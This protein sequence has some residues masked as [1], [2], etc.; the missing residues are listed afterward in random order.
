MQYSIM[1]I[2]NLIVAIIVIV[3]AVNW[4]AVAGL[5]MDLVKMI[6]PGHAD[7]ERYI[8]IA[9][10]LAGIYYAYLVYTWKTQQ[11]ETAAPSA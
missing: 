5:N 1:H 7:I 9:V 10:G 3:G 6:T 2:L 8:K 4:G 11:Q